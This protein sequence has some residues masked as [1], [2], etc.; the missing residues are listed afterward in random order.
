MKRAFTRTEPKSTDDW[1][2]RHIKNELTR[3]VFLYIPKLHDDRSLAV[4][5]TEIYD[6]TRKRWIFKQPDH[7]EIVR[8]LFPF[9]ARRTPDV[10]FQRRNENESQG[11]QFEESEED[12]DEEEHEEDYNNET[13]S[14]VLVFKGTRYSDISTSAQD[15]VN[16]IISE[17]YMHVGYPSSEKTESFDSMAFYTKIY[18]GEKNN[19]N[20]N[21][22]E[23]VCTW[24]NIQG[25]LLHFQDTPTKHISSKT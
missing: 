6:T 19:E 24:G 8:H 9:Y 18:K 15:I 10:Y 21:D 11:G 2:E 7:T 14:V 4:P 16:V 1:I 13:H 25:N 3:T 22:K 20:L 5:I 12:N 23:W 17:I